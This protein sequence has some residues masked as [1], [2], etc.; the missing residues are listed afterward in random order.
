MQIPATEQKAMTVDLYFKRKGIKERI[1]E[2]NTADFF[3]FFIGL[4]DNFC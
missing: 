4:K 3:L 1:N 2:G